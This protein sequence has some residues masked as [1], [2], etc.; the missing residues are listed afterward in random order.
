MNSNLHAVYMIKFTHLYS[1]VHWI[2]HVKGIV[3]VLSVL[4]ELVCTNDSYRWPKSKYCCCVLSSA[5]S[6]ISAFFCTGRKISCSMIMSIDSIFTYSLCRLSIFHNSIGSDRVWLT[7]VLC[8]VWMGFF[9]SLSVCRL[10]I[11]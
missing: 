6:I 1:I 7:F 2:S 11:E 8:Y 3:C 9:L 10:D 5:D 4:Y